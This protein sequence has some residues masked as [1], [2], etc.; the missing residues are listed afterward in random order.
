MLLFAAESFAGDLDVVI[1][2]MLYNPPRGLDDAEFI[3]LYN[4][5]E[6]AV[7]L[8]GWFF[9]GG[10]RF[11]FPGGVSLEPDDYLLVV[12]DISLTRTLYPDATLVGNYSGRLDNGGERIR[13]RNAAGTLIEDFGYSDGGGWPERADG[14]GASL[15]RLRPGSEPW[16]ADSWASSFT[17]LG[18]PGKANT[19][20]TLVARVGGTGIETSPSAIPAGLTVNEVSAPGDGTGWVELFNDCSGGG[21]VSGFGLSDDAAN[22]LRYVFSDGSIVACGGFLSVAEPELGFAL[23]SESTLMLTDPTGTVLVDGKSYSIAV[24]ALTA[25]SFPDGDDD[26]QLLSAAT[27]GGSNRAP[28]DRG[29]RINEIMYH[30]AS[31]PNDEEL[32]WIEIHNTGSTPVNLSDWRVT[33]GFEFE[34]PDGWAIE[35][36]G[37]LVI[38]GDPA[39]IEAHYGLAG[40]LGP[41]DGSLRNDDETIRIEDY[42]GNVVDEIHYAD[43]GRWP[44]EADGEG[45]SLEL[46]N[47]AAPTRQNGQAWAASF[48]DGTPGAVNSRYSASVA[49]VISRVRHSPPVPGA[50]QAV[51]VSA[52]VEAMAEMSRV[53]LFYKA[54]DRSTFSVVPMADDGVSEDGSAGDSV[55]G[56]SLPGQVLGTVVE[57]FIQ[58]EDSAAN[59]RFLPA[60]A[61]AETNLYLVD[62]PRPGPAAP[63]YRVVMTPRA[64]AELETRDP[65]SDELLKATF[66]AGD[67]IHYRV[68]VR[69]R[70]QNSRF[71]TPLSYRIQFTDDEPFEGIKRL[72]LNANQ[73]DHQHLGMTLFRGADVTAP[74]TRPVRFAFGVDPALTYVRMEAID[75][76]FLTRVYTS[77]NGE[78]DGDLYRGVADGDFDYRGINPDAYRTSYLKQTNVEQDGWSELINLCAMLTNTPDASL[79]TV[80]PT[81][82]DI[83][84][85]VRF[86]AVHA[87]ISTQES[88]IASNRG[89]DYFLY[90]RP[91]DGLFVLLPWDL[92]DSFRQPTTRLFQPSL[93]QIRRILTHPDYT[94]AF[95]GHLARL[96]RSHFSPERVA[97][98]IGRVAGLFPAADID[99]D[100]IFVRD[101]LAFVD[102]WLS[103]GLPADSSTEAIVTAG[104]EWRYLRGRAEPSGGNLG[105]TTIAF[106]DT[107]WET[108]PSGFGYGDGDDATILDDML[109]GYTTVYA[110]RKF[111]VDDPSVLLALDLGIDYDDGYIAFLNGVEI[112]RSNAG[113]KGTYPPFDALATDLREAGVPDFTSI[114]DVASILRAGD[115]VLAVVGFNAATDSS[116]FSLIPELGAVGGQVTSGAGP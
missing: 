19:R 98:L 31:D 91:S 16:F 54:A 10:V 66:I 24:P 89:D 55:Y 107:S 56:A 22:P 79:S 75:E 28:P 34:F 84:Q 37:Y 3:E 23:A 30:P 81:V 18:S 109:D 103:L 26:F 27:R 12:R 47:P 77:G 40:V 90:R 21:N 116:D 93:F 74:L 48:D 1:N 114:V 78:G 97:K 65:F 33:R 85:W 100:L 67:D 73:A 14:L 71:L 76:D 113:Q 115:N 99:T 57:F 83:D 39:A 112:A 105:W 8:A 63:L 36:G 44:P 58:A 42:L 25:G 2:E 95:Y 20:R 82:I 46:T 111:S 88:G 17:L 32:E 15:E 106:D 59:V 9:D 104:D 29:V 62:V 49:P 45:P 35:A 64:R 72:N 110:R 7:D 38:A 70:G 69:L 108:G 50:D 68:G 13:L 80:L 53:Q 5:G 52:R 60:T 61:P 11:T 92:D 102:S 86:F 94:T 96:G 41:F 4:S 101:R 43:D 6:D 87:L 51:T